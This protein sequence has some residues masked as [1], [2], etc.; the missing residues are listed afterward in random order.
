MGRLQELGR[1]VRD[2][3]AFYR[4]VMADPRT[5]RLARWLL[6]AAIAYLLAPIDLVPDF[7]P[8]FGQLDDALLVPGLIVL[9]M[10]RVPAEVVA[11]CRRASP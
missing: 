1:R 9:A 8:F 7:I 3:L 6:G 5:P 10:R 11:D 2:E 4:R